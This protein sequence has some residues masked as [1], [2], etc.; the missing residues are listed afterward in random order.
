VSKKGTISVNT[1]DIFPIIKKWLY[2]EHDIFLRELVSNSSDAIT[3]RSTLARTQNL[4]TEEPKISIEV[5][6]TNK[7][8]RIHD[9]G[10]GMTEEEIEKYIAQLAFSG[11]EEFVSKM[12]DIKSSDSKD[13]IIGKFGLGFYSSFMV[14]D[15]VEIDSLSMTPGARPAK[16]VCLGDTEYEFEQSTKNDIGTTIT[17]HINDESKDFLEIYKTRNTLTNYCDF[18]PY[19]I[20]LIDVDTRKKTF[21]ENLKAEKEEDKKPIDIDIINS[22]KP[23]WKQDPSSLN[24]EDYKTFFK[25]MFPMEPEPLFWIH[26]NI[27]YPFTLQGILYFPKLNPNKPFNEN[28]IRLYSKQVFVS[29]NVKDIVPEFLG[30]LKG[31]IDSSDIPLNVSR[32]SLQGDPNIKKISNYIIKKVG[33][34]LKK[35]F[36]NE[37][38]SYEA[39]W[40]DIGLF[41]KY[42]VTSDDKFDELMRSKILFKTTDSKLMTLEEYE[43]K[44]PEKFQEKLK[45]KVLF[46][47][48]GATNPGLVE[49][50]NSL[51]IPCIFTDNYL[52][53]HLTQHIEYKKQDEKEFKFVSLDEEFEG[54]TESTESADSADI[55]LKEF[56][57]TTL[58][59][60]ENE[61][62]EIEVKKLA[63]ENTPLYFKVDQNM[64]RFQNMSRQM[65][66][67]QSSAFP[68]KRTLVL[69]PKHVMIKNVIALSK[70]ANKKDL[71][72]KLV[73]YLENLANFSGTD[74]LE[75]EKKASFVKQSQEIIKDLSTLAL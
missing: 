75:P 51:E 50:I 36:T 46:T 30:L 52:D 3:K 32:S 41:V 40:E 71:A 13:E 10:L 47:E 67:M 39:A 23:L 17:L 11:A 34:S 63:T 6:K 7:L 45:G 43:Q 38:E 28:N 59:S 62:F 9:N 72:K 26:L 31:A 5:D 16:W 42:G 58:N 27:D 25:K 49:E 54:L 35:R 33:E 21:E 19:P 12:K 69:N 8:I 14:A 73:H 18:M 68:I 44:V 56:F 15:K 20:E 29:D 4:E 60:K 55:E 53:P 24:D 37:R 61:N 48:I 22:T 65:G 74:T 2:S 64:K 66:G 57:E 70:D 1:T